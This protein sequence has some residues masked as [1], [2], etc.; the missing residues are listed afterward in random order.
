MPPDSKIKN[1]CQKLV[2]GKDKPD[3]G[4]IEKDG[5]LVDSPVPI[6]DE[7]GHPGGSQNVGALHLP[8]PSPPPPHSHVHD[9]F[10]L[11]LEQNLNGMAHSAECQAPGENPYCRDCGNG[12]SVRPTDVLPNNDNPFSGL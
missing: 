6:D 3:A 7:E 1:N 2:V 11:W 9:S 5:P 8:R 4:M 12:S 10:V